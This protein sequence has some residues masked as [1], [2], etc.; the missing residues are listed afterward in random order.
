MRVR[1]A[2]GA[3]L[4]WR[5]LGVVGGLAI[6]AGAWAAFAPL[7]PGPREVVYVLGGGRGLPRAAKEGHAVPPARLRLT[8]GHVLVVR[9]EGSEVQQFGPLPLA[10]GQVYR[11]PLPSPGEYQFACASHPGGR[12]S[13]LVEA[14]PPP[15]WPRLRWRLANLF[16]R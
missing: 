12:I 11:L 2:C 15:G 16:A 7:P 10:P 3:A 4:L 6:C 1:R 8:A 14:P 13:L 9:N 5:A